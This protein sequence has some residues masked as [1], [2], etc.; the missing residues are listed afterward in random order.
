MRLI[1]FPKEELETYQA[2]A[3]ESSEALGDVEVRILRLAE[4]PCEIA[5]IF[6]ALHTVKG[7]SGFVNLPEFTQLSHHLENLFDFFRQKK[8]PVTPPLVD[9]FLENV[10]TLTQMIAGMK[11]A[12]ASHLETSD[13]IQIEIE[14]IDICEGLQKLESHLAALLSDTPAFIHPNPC[15]DPGDERSRVK[16][17]SNELKEVFGPDPDFSFSLD[18]G[19]EEEEV[20]RA[21]KGAPAKPIDPAKKEEVFAITEEMW[22]SFYKESAE[23]LGEIEQLLLEQEKNF[24]DKLILLDM[25]RLLHSFKGNC[26]FFGL[27]EMETLSHR[28]ESALGAFTRE[29]LE[30]SPKL[31]PLTLK[32]VDALRLAA[33]GLF[34]AG[35][36]K[37]AASAGG[38]IPSLSSLLEEIDGL[39]KETEAPTPIGEILIAQ[40][41]VKPEDVDEALEIQERK[42]G[43]ILVDSGK[44]SAEDLTKALEKQKEAE[45]KKPQAVGAGETSSNSG[46]PVREAAKDLRVDLAKLDH[47]LDLVG[48]LV[49]ATSIVDSSHLNTI[50]QELQNVTLSIRMIPIEATFRKMGRLVHDLSIK[51]RKRVQLEIRGEKTEMDKNIIELIVDPLVHMIRNSI[52]HGIEPPDE[53]TAKGKNP[54]GT[55][56]LQAL[57]EGG[58]ICVSL[59]DDGRGLSREKILQK[60]TERGL[61]KGDGA[62]LK[63]S[64]VF[65]FIFEP[66]FSTAEAITST[67][68]RG[69]G[70][71]VVKSHVDKLKGKI[72][73]DTALGVGTT[74]TLKIPLTLS[75][76]EGMK[77]RVG[78]V[79][80]T[81]PMHFISETVKPLE[82][83]LTRLADGQEIFHLRGKSYPVIRLHLLHSIKGHC[84]N[85][86]DGIL[87]LLETQGE[88][89][90]LLIDEV[91]GLQQTVVKA[92]PAY[93][94]QVQGV[95]SCSIMPSGEICLILDA[96]ELLKRASSEAG[97]NAL[98]GR[99]S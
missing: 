82:N 28:L 48:E 25:F 23:S 72:L 99:E 11:K 34:P 67:S 49:I 86:Q 39:I 41:R 43:E 63:D 61:V 20:P 78:S 95:S 13:G 84:E 44:I 56:V 21:E 22:Q 36:E 26:G 73:I 12:L 71:D 52:D 37:S 64:E 4:D 33:T 14:E 90:C 50:V 91:L 74:I 54:T 45:R 76:I 32:C 18:L 27:G 30:I 97:N 1:S 83:Q 40:G 55:V 7:N 17:S 35:A 5:P 75:I 66:G 69:V 2:F 93:L 79:L 8:V 94:G 68:G 3:V 6:R 59:R 92:L 96:P 57:Q 80:Y 65:A 98:V 53:R 62:A 47:L 38:K 51:S 81:V 15:P 87:I 85:I 10:D 88:S 77:V 19:T 70:M 24:K 89:Y 31:I 46:S 60:A 29:G 58:D 9:L 16:I 42:I